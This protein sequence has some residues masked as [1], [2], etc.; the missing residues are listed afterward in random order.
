MSGRTEEQH[1]AQT[2][3]Q[4]AHAYIRERAFN[5]THTYNSNANVD[6]D[7][8]VC[9]YDNISLLKHLIS[10]YLLSVHLYN[11]ELFD[12]SAFEQYISNC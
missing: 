11:A 8:T 7:L 9:C 2:H 3:I 1:H 5:N 10:F 12:F 6:F 4:Q